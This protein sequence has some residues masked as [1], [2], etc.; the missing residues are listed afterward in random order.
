MAKGVQVSE[1]RGVAGVKK[2]GCKNKVGH[3]KSTHV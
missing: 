3:Y 2:K 1:G